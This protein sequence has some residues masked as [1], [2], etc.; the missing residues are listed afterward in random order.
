MKILF[1]C[2]Q[3]MSNYGQSYG[4]LNSAQFVANVLNQNNIEAKVISVIDNN[5]ID[6]E[7]HKYQPSHV[8][9]EAFWVV[10]EKFDILCVLYP[11]VQWIVRAHSRIP[12]LS[13]EGIAFDWINGYIEKAREFSN[14]ELSFN[15]IQTVREIKESLRYRSLYTPNIYYPIENKYNIDY[16]FDKNKVLINIGCFGAIRPMKNHLIQAVASIMYGNL[17]GK[18]IKFHINASRIE[19]K[20]DNILKNLRN[21]FKNQVH[22]LIEH[23]W[24]SHPDFIEL[25]KTMDV[26]LQ[27]SFS[28]SFNIVAA[29]FV[30]HGI[31]LIGSREINWLSWLYQA[32]PNSASSIC[33]KIDIALF[34]RNWGL[35]NI[36]KIK[37]KIHNRYALKQWLHILQ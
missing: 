2:K 14:F 33:D 27:V 5:D 9:V 12:F 3:R 15:D 6:R 28:E 7:V 21:L 34:F 25:V 11:N 26:G 4:L 13:N 30:H 16:G 32:D 37:L 23:S 1:I 22:E 8:V 29:D 19:Q 35:H 18:K 10:P 24:L 31:P 36:N 20:G 17:N